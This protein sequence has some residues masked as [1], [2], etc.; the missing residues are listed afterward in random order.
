MTEDPRLRCLVP[1]CRRTRGRRKGEATFEGDE[2]W[3]CGVHWKTVPRTLKALGRKSVR[4]WDRRVAIAEFAEKKA[5]AAFNEY[6]ESRGDGTY[7]Q[8]LFVAWRE[9]RGSLRYAK[10]AR[11]R[12][13]RGIW[14]RMKR[15]AIESAFGLR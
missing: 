3:I 14:R 11:W 5:V 4:R 1:G 12:A 7:S 15:V 13:W 10:M 6:M 9:A 8:D 2:E